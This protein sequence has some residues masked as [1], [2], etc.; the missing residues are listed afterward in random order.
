MYG[1]G[2]NNSECALPYHIPV[3]T[4]LPKQEQRLLPT[5][6]TL[7]GINNGVII[8]VRYSL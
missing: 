4:S 5:Y 7:Y 1:I 8:Q 2:Q 3:T 6:G